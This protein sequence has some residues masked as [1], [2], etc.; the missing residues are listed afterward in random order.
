[1]TYK[2]EALELDEV[3]ALRKSCKT[4]EEEVVVN[5]LL[6][7]GMRVSELAKLKEINI[8]WQRGCINII[9][10]G[11]KRRVIPMSPMT[12]GLLRELFSHK[13][14]NVSVHEDVVGTS[15]TGKRIA[16]EIETC[17]DTNKK[18]KYNY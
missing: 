2:R 6:E 12:R 7:T 14:R 10:K 11:N 8:S 16:F 4:F 9:G 3:E 15:L 1:M 13:E 17:K 5:V 18:R